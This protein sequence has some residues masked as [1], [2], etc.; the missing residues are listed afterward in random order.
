MVPE[1]KHNYRHG[2]KNDAGRRTY[3]YRH[4]K[5]IEKGIFL[6]NSNK[7]RRKPWVTHK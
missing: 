2:D 6:A 3:E 7:K 4:M 1:R 5:N